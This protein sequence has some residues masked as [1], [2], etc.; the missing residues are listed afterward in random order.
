MAAC[1]EVSR[2]WGVIIRLKQ[3][4]ERERIWALERNKERDSVAFVKN[5]ELTG[6]S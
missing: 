3:H 2:S 5:G 1:R 4:K 6:Y